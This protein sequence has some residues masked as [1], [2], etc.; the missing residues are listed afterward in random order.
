MTGD[1]GKL[2]SMSKY[3]GERV[4]VTSNNSR[5]PIAHICKKMV[6][7]RYNA[8]KVQLNNIFHVPRIKK[9]MIL[10]PQLTSSG[11]YVLFGPEDVKVY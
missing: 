5:L 11:N 10:V 7:P 8:R 9:N 2:L 6:V 4:V 1:K 3:K